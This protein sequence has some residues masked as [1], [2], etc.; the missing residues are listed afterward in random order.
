MKNEI[1]LE[2]WRNRDEFAKRCNYDLDVMV[3]TL[4]KIERN[5]GN[6][7]VDGTKDTPTKQARQPLKTRRR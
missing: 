7:L 5:A 2:V 6:L 1:L 3:K 4:Q